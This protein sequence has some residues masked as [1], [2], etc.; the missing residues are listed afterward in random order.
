MRDAAAPAARPPRARRPRSS[1]TLVEPTIRDEVLY[2]EAL[3]LGLDENDDEVRRRLIEKMSYLTQDLADPE[4]SS[5]AELRAVLRRSARALRDPGAR[6]LRSGVLQPRHRGD[7]LQSRRRSGSR[8]SCAPAARPPTSATARRCARRTRMRRA[9]RSP[10]C[11]ATSL[12]RPCSALAPGDWTGP[13]RSDFGLH[14]VRLR[15]RSERA[16]AAVRRDRA[17]RSRG[18]RR[19]AAARGATSGVSSG[20]GRVTTSSSSSRTRRAGA[21]GAAAPA[22]PAAPA[23]PDPRSQPR[24]DGHASRRAA[25]RCVAARRPRVAHRLSPAFFGLA[26]TAPERLRRAVEGVDLGRPRGRAR[27]EGAGRLHAHG[28]RAHLRRQRRR[29][30][31][32][33]DAVVPRRARRQARS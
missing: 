13:F 4:P 11:S 17:N 20:C 18:V 29:A 5:D 21:D 7:A 23:D 2:R 15:G 3:A 33:R 22:A 6:E 8:G 14:V 24:D 1:R 10:C 9:S 25:R 30:I 16:P 27:A 31:P 28:R 32:A 12:P 26:E 19:A